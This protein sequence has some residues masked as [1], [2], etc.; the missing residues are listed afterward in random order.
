LK[1]ADPDP[2]GVLRGGSSRVAIGVGA[3]LKKEG[4]EV[5]VADD[6]WWGIRAARM[7]G[8]RTYFGDPVSEHADRHLDLIGIGRLLAMS[9]R[10]ELN[11]LACVR[12]RPE[13]GKNRVFF[14]RNISIEQGKGKTDFATS[15]QAPRLFGEDVTHGMIE[16]RLEAGWTIKHTRLGETFGWK[17]LQAQYAEA[18]MLLFLKTPNGS[19]K[20]FAVG[21]K[22]DVK[23]GSV[24]IMLVNPASRISDAPAPATIETAIE[25]AD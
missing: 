12:Y 13:F 1:V 4:F 22:V 5:L 11:T 10:R 2:N 14:L 21:E 7:A 15:L 8:L 20:V 24:A 23:P 19:L 9:T 16:E 17:D 3:A 25:S 6:D 18:P